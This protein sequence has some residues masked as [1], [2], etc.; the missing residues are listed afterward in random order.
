MAAAVAGLLL[1]ACGSDDGHPTAVINDTVLDAT[2]NVQDAHAKTDV[3]RSDAGTADASADASTEAS[4]AHPQD[5]SDS[6]ADKAE[7]AE[8]PLCMGDAGPVHLNQPTAPAQATGVCQGTIHRAATT[9][10]STGATIRLVGL[11]PDARTIA[12]FE[13]GTL[14]YA[15]RDSAT[16]AW[17][18]AHSVD[19]ITEGPIDPPSALTVCGSSS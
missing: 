12:W 4:D 16:A 5:A 6:S 11:T 3:T 9:S 19:G 1:L 14:N 18:P 7:A 10:V 17:N 8:P 15:D 13:T 2:T